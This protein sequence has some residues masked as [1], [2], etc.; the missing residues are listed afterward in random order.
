VRRVW[1]PCN[2]A[3]FGAAAFVGGAVPGVI[4]ALVLDAF[5]QDSVS[6]LR[7]G[8]FGLLAIGLDTAARIGLRW[9][10]PLA[11]FRQVPRNYGHR[12]GP[13]RAAVR[14]GLRMGFGPATILVSWVWWAAFAI[15]VMSGVTSIVLGALAFAVLRA[16]T[17]AGMTIGVH[18]G[19]AM[20]VRSAAVSRVERG[21][22]RAASII[23]VAVS[24]FA[25]VW[26]QR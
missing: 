3:L 11:V 4:V 5:G 14:Y 1:Q 22:Q 19:V 17:M 7:G 15:G 25:I 18:D 2:A 12:F 21:A 16:L 20:A 24:V 23:V 9:A 6:L 10:R 26:S 8:M 13:W